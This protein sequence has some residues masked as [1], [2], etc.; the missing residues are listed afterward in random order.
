MCE[1]EKEV[2]LARTV[3]RTVSEPGILVRLS[4]L[5]LPLIF[6]PPKEPLALPLPWPSNWKPSQAAPVPRFAG[7]VSF[8]A[9][10]AQNMCPCSL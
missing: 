6:F 2:H 1:P 9:A 8:P 10:E 7:H 5:E 3:V 4:C